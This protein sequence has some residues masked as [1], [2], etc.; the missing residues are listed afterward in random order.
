MVSVDIGFFDAMSIT[1]CASRCARRPLRPTSVTAPEMSPASMCRWIAA[2][3][4]V[5]RSDESPTSSGFAFVEAAPSG[6]T[7]SASNRETAPTDFIMRRVR[8][9]MECLLGRAKDT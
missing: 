8:F 3:I 6:K 9:C 1:P 2:W 5:R 7:R 4:L